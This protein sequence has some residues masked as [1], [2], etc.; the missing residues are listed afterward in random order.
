MTSF[1]VKKATDGIV[2]FMLIAGTLA[3]PRTLA[4]QTDNPA[5]SAVGI[6]QS[7]NVTSNITYHVG[8]GWEA[9]LDLYV[10]SGA[11]A[12]TPVLIYYHGGGWVVG[13]RLFCCTAGSALSREGLRGS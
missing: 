2:G 7:Y 1:I 5:S 10:P 3:I 12:P 11:E 13:D 6:A 9:T 4:A 8:S